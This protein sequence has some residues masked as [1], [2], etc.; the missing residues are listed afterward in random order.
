[1]KMNW[2]TDDML[3]EYVTCCKQ[4][5]EIFNILIKVDLGMIKREDAV[6]PIGLIE[7]KY[8]ALD[9]YTKVL[10]LSLNLLGVQT[11]DIK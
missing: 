3:K 8:K 7:K 9:E 11:P 6:L 10:G 1:M 4:K 2:N 5:L